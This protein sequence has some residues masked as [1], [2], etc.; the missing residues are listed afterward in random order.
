MLQ[1]ARMVPRHVMRYNPRQHNDSDSHES[2]VHPGTVQVVGSHHDV[3]HVARKPGHHDHGDVNH[4][5]A[6]EAQHIQEV[7][8]T[9]PT[10]FRQT[11]GRTKENGSPLPVTW[12][13]RSGLPA[14]EDEEDAEICDL[15]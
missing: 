6:E 1:A 4:D 14:T 3:V 8:A 9:V 13:F 10:A 12:R 2:P 5:E 7:D 11:D 15:L